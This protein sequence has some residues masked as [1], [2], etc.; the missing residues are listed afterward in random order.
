MSNTDV[1][2][3]TCGL[4]MGTLV[5]KILWTFFFFSKE[6][7]RLMANLMTQSHNTFSITHLVVPKQSGTTDTCTTTHE[8]EQFAFQDAR[9]L[10]TLGW[11]HTHPTQSCF[12]SSL[13]LH[14]HAS[15]QV[16][17]AEAVAIVCSPKHEPGFGI[18]R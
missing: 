16:M 18:F 5:S 3:E 17:L 1:G 14:T 4:L 9:D 10:M 12:M 15:Y 13:D 11:I 2:I 6:F 7:V 8:E